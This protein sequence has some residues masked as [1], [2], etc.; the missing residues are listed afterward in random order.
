M[1][2]AKIQVTRVDGYDL[3]YLSMRRSQEYP[4]DT[5][6]SDDDSSYS[7]DTSS[8]SSGNDDNLPEDHSNGYDSDLSDDS[9]RTIGYDLDNYQSNTPGCSQDCAIIIDEETQD[10]PVDLPVSE[11]DLVDVTG[12][13]DLSESRWNLNIPP[14][15]TANLRDIVERRKRRA[16]EE[17]SFN[18]P[19]IEFEAQGRNLFI[20]LLVGDFLGF[21]MCFTGIRNCTHFLT[22]ITVAPIS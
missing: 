22:K 4:S 7:S 9:E 18:H 3:Q 16:A 5:D 14:N 19:L 1:D 12:E 17:D 13:V 8:G 10:V 6:M 11:E 21:T 2:L 15:F 20:Y